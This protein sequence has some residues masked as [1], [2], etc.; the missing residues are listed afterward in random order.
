MPGG[1]ATSNYTGAQI[2]NQTPPIGSVFPDSQAGSRRTN[3]QLQAVPLLPS[4]STSTMS[5]YRDPASAEQPYKDP[6][7]FPADVP[8]VQ[9]LGVTS[10]PLKSAAFFVGAYCKDYNGE[11]LIPC[12]LSRLFSLVRYAAPEYPERTLCGMYRLTTWR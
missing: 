2:Q 5:F 8:K 7:P 6:T 4:R 3:A 11:C 1:Q 9:E 10:A 12:V